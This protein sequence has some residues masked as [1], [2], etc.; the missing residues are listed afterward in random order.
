MQNPINFEEI[1]KRIL[2]QRHELK[3]DE[4]LRLIDDKKK[5]A[6][7]LLSD[8]GAAR[9]VAQDL[10]VRISSKISGV[11]IGDLVSGLNDVTLTGV[12]IGQ[13]PIREFRKQDGTI[14]KLL[15]LILGD[16]TGTIRCVLWN[17]KAEQA[18]ASGELQG[19]IIRIAH[20]Y[21]RSSLSGTIELNLGD[22]SEIT[23]L[24]ANIENYPN[25]HKFFK[26]ITEI[27]LTD[28]EVNITGKVNS[29]PR[30]STF[31]KDEGVGKLLRLTLSDKSGTIELVAWDV[32]VEELSNIEV[33]EPLQVIGGRVRASLSGNPEVHVGNESLVLIGEPKDFR[34]VLRGHIHIS[35]LR[36]NQRNL[37]LLARVLNVG[38]PI[39]SMN[40]DKKNRYGMLLIGDESGLIR[41]FLWDDKTKLLE[42]IREGDIIL[43]NGAKTI[44]KNDEISISVGKYGKLELNPKLVAGAPPRYP[45]PIIIKE[46]RD[47]HR[48]VIIEGT[49]VREPE[50]KTV[51]L[52]NGETIKV[53]NILL[54]D[55]SGRVQISFW[56]DL[57]EKMTNLKLGTRIRVIGV[58]PK[59]V[60]SGE[61]TMTSNQLTRVE[62]LSGQE[63]IGDYL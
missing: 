3:R 61:S 37:S 30:I 6:Q 62:I 23:L 33:G 19:R 55:G 27:K 28:R 51:H 58:I 49:L 38:E 42:N 20:G 59:T 25:I 32:K 14:G 18:L 46:L 12:V 15:K 9:L 56:R 31:I 63:M 52:R 24:P 29:P 44:K 4:L 47:I 16:D 40:D 11:K 35:D 36:P 1:I 2:S 5:E 54:D 48:P 39:E 45:D 57:A 53:S 41:L 26:K 22:R 17:G 43:I 10:L 34:S 7:G 60:I 21:T 13:W 50:V 8:E